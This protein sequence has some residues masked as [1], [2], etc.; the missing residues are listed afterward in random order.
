MLQR[1]QQ[2]FLNMLKLQLLICFILF[3]LIGFSQDS[4]RKD[5]S[6]N[7][8]IIVTA[9]EENLEINQHILETGFSIHAKDT[10][11]KI[12]SFCITYPCQLKGDFALQQISFQG[13]R[14][15]VDQKYPRVWNLTGSD[16]VTFDRILVEKERQIF[17]AKPF[18]VKITK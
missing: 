11:Y 15:L 17:Y 14:G 10:S 13:T 18:I 2:L 16:F 4:R 6:Y 8:S 7:P 3:S 5:T 12:I 9:F 1:W